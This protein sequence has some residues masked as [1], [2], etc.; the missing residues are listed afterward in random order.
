MKKV[1]FM[2]FLC[3]NIVGTMLA[4]GQMLVTAESLNKRHQTINEI[5]VEPD[6]T[7][8][9]VTRESVARPRVARDLIRGDS[10]NDNVFERYNF[11]THSD[12]SST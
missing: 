1:L 10:D 8:Q 3:V 4:Q 2:L 9:H 5:V 7:I 6:G 11:M 12:L